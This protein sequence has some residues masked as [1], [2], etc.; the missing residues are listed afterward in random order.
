VPA[1]VLR[2][3]LYSAPAIGLAQAFWALL[4]QT[5]APVRARGITTGGNRRPR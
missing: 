2:R 4:G 1:E 5:A 3:R